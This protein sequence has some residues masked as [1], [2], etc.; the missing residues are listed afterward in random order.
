MATYNWSALRKQAEEAGEST[1]GFT[2]LPVGTYDVVVTKADVKSFKGGEKEGWNIQFSVDGGPEAGR[3]VFT[4]LVISPESAKAVAILL[5]QLEALGVRPVLDAG[6]TLQQVAAAM[7]NQKATI[8]VDV[9]VY[10]EKLT[11]DVKKIT[12]RAGGDP[13]A[14]QAAASIKAPAGLPI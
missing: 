7:L 8:E 5:R 4:N 1:E 14:H 6:G 9:R 11:N 10:N 3:R 2:P 13:I 12:A